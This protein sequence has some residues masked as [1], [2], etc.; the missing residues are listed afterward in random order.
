MANGERTVRDCY[1]KQHNPSSLCGHS[2]TARVQTRTHGQGCP[3]CAQEARRYRAEQPSI[4]VGA[5]HLLAESYWEANET[6]GCGPDHITLGSNKKVHLFVQD[7]CK[8]GL[9]HRL[10]A[11]P[12]RQL[13]GGS[14]FPSGMAV[15]ACNSLAVQCP[16]TAD[17]WDHR[18]NG[19]MTPDDITVQSAQ[20]VCWRLPDGKQWQQSVQEVFRM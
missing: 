4:S 11:P 15:C 14:P 13:T 2:W 5:P 17:L 16:K 6:H 3:Q 10:Q 19:S 18:E 7:E 9:V 1:C 20:L 8:L 12:I